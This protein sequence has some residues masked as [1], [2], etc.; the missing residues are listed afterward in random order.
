MT[1]TASRLAPCPGTPNCVS[2]E[3]KPGRQRMEPIPYAGTPAQTRERLLEVLRRHSRTR[4]V[5][6]E[7]AYLKAE[8]R[9]RFFR[10]V[11]DV[12]FVFDDDARQIHFRSASRFGYGDRGVNRR[13]MK[14]IRAAFL[15]S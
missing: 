14:E 7:P 6:Q 9:S 13:R 10:F 11:D 3:A 15:D 8:C 4:I 1:G 12:E 2:T 5:R